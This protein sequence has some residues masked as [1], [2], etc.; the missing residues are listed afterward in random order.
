MP[1]AKT[2]FVGGYMPHVEP[3]DPVGFHINTGE[4][5][6]HG[7]LTS[8]FGHMFNGVEIPQGAAIENRR[9]ALHMCQEWMIFLNKIGWFEHTADWDLY[10]QV[11]LYD[12]RSTHNSGVFL[13]LHPE[14][15]AN[16]YAQ[17][18]VGPTH[19][20]LEDCY[21]WDGAS[22]DEAS[23]WND[24]VRNEKKAEGQDPTGDLYIPIELVHRV[25]VGWD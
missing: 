11:H 17:P 10:A 1:D 2:V 24:F 5:L 6:A 13:K 19:V 8:S 18:D 15:D 16:D 4:E 12:G 7:S 20:V 22:P 23:L 3:S 14:V 9:V 25:N 21:L